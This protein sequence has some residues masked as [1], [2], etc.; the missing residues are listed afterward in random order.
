MISKFGKNKKIHEPLSKIHNKPQRRQS[1][2]VGKHKFS[3]LFHDVLT[4]NEGEI[5]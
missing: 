3:K 5:L 4:E 2:P 1:Q